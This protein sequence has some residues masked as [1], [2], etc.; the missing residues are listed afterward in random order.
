MSEEVKGDNVA[1][2]NTGDASNQEINAESGNAG[3]GKQS[4]KFETYSRVLGK[5]KTTEAQFS[6]LQDKINSLEQEKLEAEGNKDQLID[7]LRKELNERKAR[8]KQIVGSIA[9]SQGRNA[10]VDQ[11]VK[12]GCNSPEILTKLLESD[13]QGLDYDSEFKPDQ[14]QVK[15]L[16]EEAR[17]KNPILFSKEPPKTANH[18][19][20][21]TPPKQKT[22]K[23]LVEMTDEEFNQVWSKFGSAP[24][25]K[26]A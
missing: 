14:E 3:D 18:N 24:T 1:P 6:E 5:L 15:L 7:S 13:L 19:L 21:T 16:I 10:L 2:E 25:G 22:T 20:N 4:V 23:P 8:E 17:K 12:A 26:R 9:L 11:A